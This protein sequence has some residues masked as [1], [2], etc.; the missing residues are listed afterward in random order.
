MNFEVFVKVSKQC[1]MI[2]V[3]SIKIK[4]KEETEN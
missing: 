3:L 4:T 2:H 1:Q